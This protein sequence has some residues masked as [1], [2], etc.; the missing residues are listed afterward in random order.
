[1]KTDPDTGI[2]G[3]R[4]SDGMGFHE[5]LQLAE[6]ISAKPLYVTNIGV[7]HTDYLPYTSL[8]GYIQDALDALEYANGD[9][10]TT[11]GAMRTAKGHPKPFDI[12]Y[13]EIGNEKRA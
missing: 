11:Y 2:F 5:F 3:Y 8:D 7:S 12:E 6:D 9:T 10:T 1:M 4:T 13:I